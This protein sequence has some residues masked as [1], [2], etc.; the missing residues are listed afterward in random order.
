MKFFKYFL[1]LPFF[2]ACAKEYSCESCQ[3]ICNR[4]TAGLT[5]I[6]T[7]INGEVL[8]IGSTYRTKWAGTVPGIQE[9]TVLLWYPGDSLGITAQSLVLGKIKNNDCEF[10][11]QVPTIPYSRPNEFSLSFVAQGYSVQGPLFTIRR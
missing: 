7:P 6:R 11:W 5:T 2:A 4:D 3:Q 8:Y 9:Y 10:F 1:L